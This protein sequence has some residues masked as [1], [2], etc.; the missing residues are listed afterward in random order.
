MGYSCL[1]LKHWPA[2]KG[3]AA[4]SEPTIQGVDCLNSVGEG[5]GNPPG[6][7]RGRGGSHRGAGTAAKS[8]LFF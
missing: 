3:R 1:R 2:E 6:V 4:E 5:A 7:T 8:R